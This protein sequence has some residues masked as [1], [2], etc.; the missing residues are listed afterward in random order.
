M[1]QRLSQNCLT[2]NLSSITYVVM[3]E[4]PTKLIKLGQWIQLGILIPRQMNSY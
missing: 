3:Y 4:I 1:H 2:L